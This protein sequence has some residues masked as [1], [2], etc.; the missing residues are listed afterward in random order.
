L[1]D[2]GPQALAGL[3]TLEFDS[4]SDVVAARLIANGGSTRIT[5]DLFVSAEGVNSRARQL[6]FPDWPTTPDPVP[7]M[8]GLVRSIE[9]V[10]WAGRALNKFHAADGGVAFGVLPVGPE[11]VVWYLQF[12]SQ[13]HPLP[14]EAM[15]SNNGAALARR[16]FVERLVGGWADPIPS[17]LAASD[18]SAV[19]LWRPIETGLIPQFHRGN[20]V[21][22]GD[23]AHP[24]S[25][26]TSQGVASA[27]G[28]AVALAEAVDAA[29]SGK[30]TLEDALN[31]YSTERHAQCAP[32]LAKGLELTREFLA[33]MVAQRLLLPIA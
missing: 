12:D 6:L 33:P 24:L 10:R 26:F 2:D 4:H 21:L 15:H 16:R 30:T 22:V 17:L 31:R 13:R 20:L 9:A 7:E 29:T 8:V 19:H 3:D 1:G 27:L 11:H 14:A 18:F 25:P 23:A 32:L 5:A 28:D